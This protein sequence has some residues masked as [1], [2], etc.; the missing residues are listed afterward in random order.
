MPK[1]HSALDLEDKAMDALRR[2]ET[3]ATLMESSSLDD[4]A[5]LDA[6]VVAEVARMISDEASK[7]RVVLEATWRL[8]SKSKS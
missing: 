7:L 6:E 3:L 1:P 8:M 5:P 4:T 2:V